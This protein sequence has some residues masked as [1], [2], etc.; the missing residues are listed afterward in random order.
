MP[1]HP[2]A[3]R[4][5][6]LTIAVCAASGPYRADAPGDRPAEPEQRR[7]VQKVSVE[8]L[9][10]KTSS[11]TFTGWIHDGCVK[12]ADPEGVVSR[13]PITRVD[14]YVSGGKGYINGIRLWYGKDG[15]GL[16]HGYTKDV[17]PAT[18]MIPDG[19]RIT[20]VEGRIHRYYV[21]QLQFFTDGGHSSPV[22]GGMSGTTT[23]FVAEDP[24]KGA[25]RTISGHANLRRHA[26][27]NRAL[28]S[29]TFHFGAPYFIKSIDYDLAALDAAR[30]ETPPERCASQDFSNKTS[31]E[32][33][34][35]YTSSLRVAKTTKLT[36]EHSLTL[37][38]SQTIVA[39]ASAKIAGFGV[40]VSTATSW[41]VSS[42]AGFGQTYS[43]TREDTV[44]WS[45]PVR[46]PPNTR[47]VATSTWR[48]YPVRIPF[49][50]TI[51]WYEGTKDNIK[52]EVT[53]PG[54]YEDVRVDDLKHDFAET[55]LK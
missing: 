24:A 20:R 23:P 13:G 14:V 4:V 2:A 32:Q 55:P 10:F 35:T 17:P 16:T 5:L 30:L 12:F 27:L 48:K 29:M 36:F 44:S 46:V 21:S 31:V 28:A 15:A 37:A 47:I 18:W 49:T 39:E 11:P 22:F 6:L 38:F 3:L 40:G 45:V 8:D 43:T 7:R 51:A 41:G 25:L 1:R 26:S 53:L 19:E 9:W 52:K 50:Y 54:L 34:S 33:S 42:T